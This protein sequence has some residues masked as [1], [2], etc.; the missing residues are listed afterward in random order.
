[1]RRSGRSSVSKT[2]HLNL[3]VRRHHETGSPSGR[4]KES[5]SSIDVLIVLVMRQRSSTPLSLGSLKTRKSPLKSEL[6]VG[7]SV[8]PE[9]RIQ[10]GRPVYHGWVTAVNHTVYYPHWRFC[11]A[12][13]PVELR[14]FH[15]QTNCHR[16]VLANAA[17]DN[18]GRVHLGFP[19]ERW[20][21]RKMKPTAGSGP[22]AEDSAC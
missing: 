1:M 4:I 19:I 21:V 6:W 16:L 14:C 22:P 8:D 5:S 12:S 17:N 9:F 2:E 15:A 3:C 13:L 18:S 7:K 20:E 11:T 10:Y